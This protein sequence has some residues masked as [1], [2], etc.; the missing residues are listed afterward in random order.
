M[1]K[2]TITFLGLFIAMSGNLYAQPQF[3]TLVFTRTA[4]WHHQS[5]STGVDAIKKLMES[6]Q[7]HKSKV[8]ELD[9]EHTRLTQD[10]ESKLEEI[11]VAK[12]EQLKEREENEKNFSKTMEN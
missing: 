9:G 12:S 5:I 4:G 3:R 2:I 10:L 8:S 11:E 6:R 1:R 7:K